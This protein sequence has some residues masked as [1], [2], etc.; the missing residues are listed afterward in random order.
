M[1]RSTSQTTASTTRPAPIHPVTGFVPTVVTS[2][3]GSSSQPRYP[4]YHLQNGSQRHNE[5]TTAHRRR[6]RVS[7]VLYRFMRRQMVGNLP[8][9]FP[10]YSRYR[11]HLPQSRHLNPPQVHLQARQRLQLLPRLVLMLKQMRK[12]SRRR[13]TRKNLMFSH[14][15]CRPILSEW[16]R[17]VSIIRRPQVT[18]A[19]KFDFSKSS[20]SDWKTVKVSSDASMVS[21]AFPRSKA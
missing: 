2:P 12:Q 16:N 6:T 17:W 10:S 18:E 21:V 11:R 19:Q 5:W 15:Y 14:R 8:S 9:G 13:L 4:R 7:R 20:L 1:I 3:I